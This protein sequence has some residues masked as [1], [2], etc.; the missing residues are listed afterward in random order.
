[1]RSERTNV[2]EEGLVSLRSCF[3][4]GS[5]EEE[6]NARKVRRRAILTSIIVQIL[7]L[8]A[9]VLYPMLSHGERL[10][11]TVVTP[12]VPYTHSGGQP[13]QPKG[14]RHPTTRPQTYG[15]S[16]PSYI[17]PTIVTTDHGTPAENNPGP[18][19]P[20]IPGTL[21]GDRIPGA[22]FATGPESGPV[23]PQQEVRTHENKRISIGQIEPAMLTR[24]VEPVY[25]QLPLQLH[26]E[27]R[28]EL[29][30][31]IA[32]DGTIQS[33][34]VVSGDPLFYASALAAVRQWRYKATILDG[35]AV[36]VETQISVI[37]RL[38]H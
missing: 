17:P 16:A 32:T 10:P 7:V 11:F 31:I 9:L 14:Q 8:A 18:D 36:E 2:A 21:V 19:G 12:T 23:K 27:G 33:L 24:R 37:Y 20:N 22:P 25:P 35:Q 5:A 6:K 34:E 1:M 13:R 38:N 15:I 28:V 29:R 4:E 3:L 30:A 26:R